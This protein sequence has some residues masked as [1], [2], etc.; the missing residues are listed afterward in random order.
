MQK[1]KKVNSGIISIQNGLSEAKKVKK[2]LVPNS[3]HTRTGQEDSEKNS[4]KCQKIKKTLSA[5]FLAKTGSYRPRKRERNFRREFR[6]YSTR[7]S[8]FRKKL[9]KNSKN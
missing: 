8:K 1:I 5:L 6:S 4:K 2:N 9:Q 7:G 3:V